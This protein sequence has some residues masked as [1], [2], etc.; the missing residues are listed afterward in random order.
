LTLAII[1]ILL[2]LESAR[3]AGGAIF[4]VITLIFTIYPLFAQLLPGGLGGIG[5]TFPSMIGFHAFECEGLLGL[6]MKV[7]GQILLG[8]LVFAAMLLGTGAGD[9]FLNLALSLAGRFRGGP[10]K[11]AVIASGF[12][13]SMSGSIISNVAATGSVTIPAMKRTGYPPHYAGAIEACASTGGVLM[14]PVMGA[15]AFIMASLLEIPY[16]T[17]IMAAFI[18]SI[19][20]YLGLLLQTDAYAA[21]TGLRGL[22][23]EEIPSKWQTLKQGWHFLLVLVFLLWGLLYMRWEALTPFYASALLILLSTVRKETRLGP[24]RFMAMVEGVGKLL[25]E[26][27]GI[28]LPIGLIISGLVITG[29]APALTAGIVALSG[30][31]PIIALFLGAIICYIMGMVGLLT[32]AYIFLALTLAPSLVQLGFDVFAAHM[33]I[34]YYAMLSAIT[35]PVAVA[36]FLGSAIAGAHPMRTALQAMRLGIVIYFIPFFFVFEP[37]LVLRGTP[38]ETLWFFLT[39]VLGIVFLAGGIEGYLIRVGRV[40]VVMRPLLAIAGILIAVPNLRTDVIG[41]ILALVLVAFLLIR[42]KASATG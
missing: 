13:G 29:M 26:T 17:I 41:A 28:I 22:S 42:K 19:L 7:I 3:R 27:L 35:P 1:L 37:A 11:V 18:P 38:W 33:F 40:P 25:V 36:A 10:A 39:A 6:P 34:I 12:F 16:A 23:R 32:P 21:R 24:R 20:Y 4:G 31:I 15:A 2:T 9:F 8:F 14:P 30:G 5:Y